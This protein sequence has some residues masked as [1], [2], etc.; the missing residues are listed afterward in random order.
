M[1]E[2][3]HIATLSE[4]ELPYTTLIDALVIGAFTLRALASFFDC[5]KHTSYLQQ[6]DNVI[7]LSEVGK[8]DQPALKDEP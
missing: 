2:S 7:K 6:L 5:S 3:I 1:H 4:R 8:L